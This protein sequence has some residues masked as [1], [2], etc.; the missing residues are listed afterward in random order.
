MCESATGLALLGFA[1][2]K[3]RFALC[4]WNFFVVATEICLITGRPNGGVGLSGLRPHTGG[5]RSALLSSAVEDRGDYL[6]IRRPS[7]TAML[8]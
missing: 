3:L 4:R 1:R 7:K 2:P 6:V 5:R 8:F